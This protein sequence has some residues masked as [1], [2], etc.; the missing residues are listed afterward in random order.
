MILD[1]LSASC[2]KPT[3]WICEHVPK[4]SEIDQISNIH[5]Q[6]LNPRQPIYPCG[7]NRHQCQPVI[8]LTVTYT[9][10]HLFRDTLNHKFQIHLQKYL[11]IMKNKTFF[12]ATIVVIFIIYCEQ[13]R[14]ELRRCTD[15]LATREA[16]YP[17]RLPRT[18]TK[19]HVHIRYSKL[20]NGISHKKIES[21][22]SDIKLP[23]NIDTSKWG[24]E[25]NRSNV[26]NNA[27][28]RNVWKET[29]WN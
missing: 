7:H 23:P 19:S 18:R 8:L 15:H 25:S 5:V 14:C 10:A 2:V 9:C 28:H 24:I 21:K 13:W 20:H 4:Y 17:R 22:Q 26:Y 12:E 1:L 11:I 27:L 16:L 29:P 3:K 6:Y